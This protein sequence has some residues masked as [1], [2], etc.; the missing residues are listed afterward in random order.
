MEDIYPRYQARLATMNAA[1]FGDLI[2][3][4]VTLL[5]SDRELRRELQARFRVVLVDEFQDANRAQ[6]EL[7][8]LLHGPHTY[9]CVVGDDD[10]SIYRFAV[11]RSTGF[12]PFRNGSPAPR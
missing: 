12:S 10:Q 4:P 2:L 9:L 1:D 8:R 7:L 6:F 5:R 11:P 3:H